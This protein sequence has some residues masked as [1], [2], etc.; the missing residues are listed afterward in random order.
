MQSWRLLGAPCIPQI[1]ARH[2]L[3]VVLRTT[4]HQKKALTFQRESM[5]A[6]IFVNRVPCRLAEDICNDLDTHT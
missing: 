1:V 5:K 3:G 4:T 6:Q 2:T